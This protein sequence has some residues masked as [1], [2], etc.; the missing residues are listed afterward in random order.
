MLL[1]GLS[2][3]ALMR[4]EAEEAAHLAALLI[5]EGRRG[6]RPGAELKGLV[7]LSLSR[8]ADSPAADADMREAVRLASG[9]GIVAPFA[10]E[11]RRLVPSLRRVMAAETSKLVQRHA[12]AIL[13]V[14]DGEQQ[15]ADADALSDRE[16][17]IVSH[18]ADGASNK[19][20]ARRLGLTENTIKFHLKKVYAKLGVSTRRQAVAHA[21]QAR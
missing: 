18:L 20:I 3:L 5:Q 12:A 10:E 11:G 13:R 14:I 17:E 16:A 19:L 15:F 2:G 8:G 1:R 6:A 9:E 7:L 4:G 21:L